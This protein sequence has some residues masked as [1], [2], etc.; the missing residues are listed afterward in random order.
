MQ[1]VSNLRV[2]SSNLLARHALFGLV[3]YSRCLSPPLIFD[4]QNKCSFV[5]KHECC[6]N[7]ERKF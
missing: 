7:L 2:F 1:Q 4:G 5:Y 3:L 6:Y